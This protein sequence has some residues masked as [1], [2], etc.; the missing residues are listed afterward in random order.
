MIRPLLAFLSTAIVAAA[1]ARDEWL[2]RM[3]PITPLGYIARHTATPV[4]ID[5]QLDDA[6][7]AAAEWTSDFV[8][9]EGDAKP[10]PRLR[11][12]AKLLWDDHYLYIAAELEEPHV[13]ATLTKHDSVIF[14]DNDFEV[15]LDPVGDTHGYF[16]FE[17]NAL[18]TGWDLYLVKP[19]QD[20]GPPLNEWEIP[21][22][23]KAV[24]V[25]GTLNDPRDTDRSWTV[26]LAFPWEAFSYHGREVKRPKDGDQW[27]LN[28][29]RVQWKTKIDQDAYVK[30]PDTPEDNWVWTPQGVIDMHRPEMWGLLQFTRRPAG[31][32]VG[33][34]PLPGAAARAR[35]LELYY[36]QRDFFAA[37]QRW[38]T[39]LDELGWSEPGTGDAKAQP[40]VRLVSS[41]DG[42]D[43]KVS[44][45]Q[46]DR[47]WSWCIR[48]DRRLTL[49]A[50]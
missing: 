19:Y 20:G 49:A 24:Q 44:F 42:Y 16:E 25:N 7:W 6:T 17:I 36:A 11:T 50:E 47:Q 38:A 10:H 23:K 21:G 3:E 37:H 2:T 33:V 45:S 29:S 32:P 39:T 43:A 15:F 40:S 27:R 1:S 12:R 13:W 26:E 41:H 22:L 14:H 46:L 35:A 48:Q 28:F 31:E 34:T 4:V 18:N 30:L 5:G 9:I 8:D